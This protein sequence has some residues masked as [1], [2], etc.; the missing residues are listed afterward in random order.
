MN[1]IP[2]ETVEEVWKTVGAL[3][4]ERTQEA[5]K[6]MAEEQPFII[7]YLMAASEET[8]AKEEQDLLLYIAFV[9]WRIM[10]AGGASAMARTGEMIQSAEETNRKMLE[11]LEGEPETDLSRTIQSLL[12]SY[13]QPAVLRFALEALMEET[14]DGEAFTAENK[15][16]AMI[17]LKTI[18]DCLNQ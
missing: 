17:Y 16:L 5:M 10:S 2:D 18:I 11:Y 1:R 9:V 15:G 13:G 12:A 8:F 4:P 6:E 14:A 3:S 7:G